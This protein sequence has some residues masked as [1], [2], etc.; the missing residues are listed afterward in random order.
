[1]DLAELPGTKNGS[2]RRPSLNHHISIKPT[3]KKKKM[4]KLLSRVEKTPVSCGFTIL[5]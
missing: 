3:V 2:K 4:E 5:L 1:M